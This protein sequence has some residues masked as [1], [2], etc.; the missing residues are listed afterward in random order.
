MLNAHGTVQDE[1]NVATNENC[2]LRNVEVCFKT[3]TS[4]FYAK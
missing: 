3:Q 1:N 4:T 2:I